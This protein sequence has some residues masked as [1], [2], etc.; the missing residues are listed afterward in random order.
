MY[1]RDVMSREVV[2]VRP[3]TPLKD[4]ARLMIGRGISGVPVVDDAGIVVG[5][6]SEADFIIKERGAEAVR[7][8]PLARLLGESREAEAEFAKVVAERAGSAMSSPPITIEAGAL[9]RTA[10]SLMVER[11]V[12][13]LPVVEDGRLVGIVSRADLIRAYL[14]SDAELE[15]EIRE[16]VLGR[17]LWV[18]TSDMTLR[19][20]DGVVLVGGTVD[21]RSTAELVVSH[22]ARVAG[23]LAVESS[24][25]WR[26]DDSE[27]VAPEPDLVSPFGSC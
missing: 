11:A 7:R 26:L 20:R 16:E 8:R 12:N 23:V 17:E 9:L 18:D 5:V 24:L 21:R 3:E 10:A 27:V 6:V 25:A 15:R 19:V 1:V 2:S 4:V 14:R 22:A 13:R